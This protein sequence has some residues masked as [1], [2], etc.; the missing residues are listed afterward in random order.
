MVKSISEINV[1]WISSLSY[2]PATT[3]SDSCGGYFYIKPNKIVIALRATNN[4]TFSSY[5]LG[6]ISHVTSPISRSH[7]AQS[8]IKV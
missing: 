8:P 2:T 3:G 7:S 4:S 5:P 6:N 1:F